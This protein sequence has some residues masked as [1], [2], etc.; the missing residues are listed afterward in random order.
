MSV[1]LLGF[2]Q[3]EAAVGYYSMAQKIVDVINTIVLSLATVLLPRLANYSGNEQYAEFK[4]LGDKA[5]SFVLAISLPICV[6]MALLAKP[7]IMVLFGETY[8]PS[9]SVLMIW[10]PIIVSIGLS[11]VYGKD[12]LYSLGHETLM[13]KCTFVGMVVFLVV[14][15]PAIMHFSIVGAALASFFA[16]TAVTGCMMLFGK[17]WHSCTIMRRDNLAYVLASLIM[18][19]AV[20]ISTISFNTYLLKLLV[21][22]SIGPI[23]YFGVLGIMHNSIFN[24]VLQFVKIKKQNKYYE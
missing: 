8:N 15:V 6:G 5:L 23:V 13:T 16:E 17:K 21:G 18:G 2:L 11:Q 12:I 14:G 9:V 10:A 3:S 1:F 24:E 4:Q 19:S 7:I 20:Y 22:V